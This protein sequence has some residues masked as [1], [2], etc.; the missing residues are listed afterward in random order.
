MK[1]SGPQHGSHSV[2]EFLKGLSCRSVHSTP[3]AGLS[4]VDTIQVHLF[5]SALLVSDTET[6]SRILRAVTTRE[7]LRPDSPVAH[8]FSF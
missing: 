3:Y 6:P 1:T 2:V 8:G 4:G 5:D 7:H